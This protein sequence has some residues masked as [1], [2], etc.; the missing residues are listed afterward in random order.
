MTD[1]V[2]S[3][4][5]VF[6]LGA[7]ASREAAMPLATE[8]TQLMLAAVQNTPEERINAH[9]LNYVVSAIMAHRGR[10]GKSPLHY[11]DIETVV[12]AVEL[13]AAR[14]DVELTPFVQSWDPGVGAAETATLTQ[15]QQLA[16]KICDD[17]GN[18]G[19]LGLGSAALARD[20]GAFVRAEV[21]LA[22]GAPMPSCSTSWSASW[23]TSSPSTTTARKSLTTSPRW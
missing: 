12:S 19:A 10:A 6:L 16:Q 5:V 14:D 15:Q 21:G 8:M 22:P 4:D 17:L 23:S 13:L 1:E 7:G 9:P 2:A 20:L 11:P 18:I 3:G